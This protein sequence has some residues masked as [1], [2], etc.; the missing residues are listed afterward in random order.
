MTSP[1]DTVI[2]TAANAR[3][4]PLLRQAVQSVNDAGL[5]PQVA[6][7]VL[8]LGLTD[9]QRDELAPLI[10]A[11]AEARWDMDFPGRD[12][13]PPYFKAMTARPHL[14]EYF[15]GHDIYIWLD[16]DAWVQDPTVLDMF[17]DAARGGQ[18]AVVPELDRSYSSFYKRPRPYWRTQ[19][20]RAFNWSY[21]LCVAD[22]LARNPILNSGVFALKADAPHW[23]LWHDALAQ[24]LTRR[25][26]FASRTGLWAHV[27][28]QTALNYVV[29]HDKAPTTFLPAYC[30][31]FCGKAVPMWDADAAK[32]VEPHAPH[33]PLGIVHLAGDGVQDRV[34]DM[35]TSTGGRLSS[36]LTYDAVRGLAGG[37]PRR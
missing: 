22:R 21:G 7:A 18:L 33:R 34:F 5:R 35:A 30:N 6:L 1:R 19:N 20:F 9:E 12:D 26:L 27:S 23:D 16:A 11:R 36:R 31:W 4:F 24:A 13:F 2:V 3:Y 15:P 37:G 10:D 14:P 17:V 25:R 29:F 8:D 32:L 28:E